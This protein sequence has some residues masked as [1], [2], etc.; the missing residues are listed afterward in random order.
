M[1]LKQGGENM[2]GSMR[3]R[4][5]ILAEKS[6]AHHLHAHA[7]LGVSSCKSFAA[8]RLY[9]QDPHTRS[10]SR[11]T[12]ISTIFCLVSIDKLR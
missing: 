9:I 10:R 11:D 4:P 3:L 12:N 8:H 7:T 1:G 6:P 2:H 5:Q